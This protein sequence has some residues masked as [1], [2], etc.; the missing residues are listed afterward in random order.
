[1]NLDTPR[2]PAPLLS[3]AEGTRVLPPNRMALLR[4][5]NTGDPSALMH[6]AVSLI[7]VPLRPQSCGEQTVTQ[8][9]LAKQTLASWTGADTACC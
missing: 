6:V 8:E 5:D 7:Y 1:M 3:T 9:Y 4:R 2:P